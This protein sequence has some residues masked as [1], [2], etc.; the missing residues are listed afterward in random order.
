MMKKIEDLR[1]KMDE[2]KL[3]GGLRRIERQHKKGK[4]TAR[5]RLERLMDPGSFVEL[6][7]FVTHRCTDFG[8]ERRKGLGDGVVTGHGTVDGRLVFVYAQDFTFMG[9]SLGEM[10]AKKIC[11]V[12]DLA[13]E[14]GAPIIGLNDSGGARI[15]EGVAALG[16]YGEIFS[17][18][19]M[20]SG[21]VPQIIAIMGPC[22]GGAV[23]SPALADFIIM[24]RGTSQIFITGPAVI[25][26]VTGEEVTFEQLGSADV[27]S[28]VSGVASLVAEN[29]EECIRMVK[30]L[31]SYLPSN[32]L[33]DPPIAEVEGRGEKPEDE[34]LLDIVPADPRKVYDMRNVINRVVDEGTFFEIHEDYAPNALTGFARLRGRT[35]GVVANQPIA[36]AGCMDIDSSDKVAR[37]VRFCDAFNTPLITFTDV[38]GY[39]PG[40][41]QEYGG[42]IRHGAKVIYA[43]S[44]ATV[45][46]ITVIL[47]KAYGGGYIAMCSKH[48]GAD[49]VFA[50]PTAEIAVVG[51]EGAIDIIFRRE[52]A[53][54]EKPEEARTRLVE[55][56]RE[57]FANPYVA[58]SMGYVDQVIEPQETRRRLLEALERLMSKRSIRPGPRTKHGNIPV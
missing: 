28:Q 27:H 7:A 38:P 9:G 22:A 47:R 4:L 23:Y 58:A 40:V 43:Y 32:N 15:Q 41:K 8:M 24:V 1:R 35:V 25:K 17:R 51:P 49:V 10:H 16:G 36:Y 50:W 29:D 26:A 31:L 18:N 57:K 42:I 46:K 21:A 33:E 13:M 2:A 53:E 39:L 30:R 45:P 55:E 54:A 5:E 20:A 48:L 56:Y 44:E 14:M 52:I 3:G 19:V 12:M 34:E 11:K 37:F 6:D